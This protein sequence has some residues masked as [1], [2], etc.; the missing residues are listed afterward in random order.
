[1]AFIL[2]LRNSLLGYVWNDF[3]ESLGYIE[4]SLNWCN[5]NFSISGVDREWTV[6]RKLEIENVGIGSR[7]YDL[8]LLLSKISPLPLRS[9]NRKSKRRWTSS[10]L[11]LRTP[12]FYQ[13]WFT[14]VRIMSSA[15]IK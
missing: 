7:T 14:R 6:F 10:G 1:M 11:T 13:N 2:C 4:L 3:D 5:V 8:N 12:T 9:R 15:H